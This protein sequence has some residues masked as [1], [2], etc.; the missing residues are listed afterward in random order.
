MCRTPTGQ[1]QA[2]PLSERHGRIYWTPEHRASSDGPE[3]SEQAD[4]GDHWPTAVG[5]RRLS[6]ELS[7]RRDTDPGRPYR[8]GNRRLDDAP[9]QSGLF[10]CD[11]PGLAHREGRYA[12]ADH[13]GVGGGLTGWLSR[14]CDCSS[15]VRQVQQ[16]S[17]RW[18][19]FHQ[20]DSCDGTGVIW[21]TGDG[22]CPL[23]MFRP[24]P[25]FQFCPPRHG[26]GFSAA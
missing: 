7:G 26:L 9:V 10:I 13:G 21:N 25:A 20:I 2:G 11:E 18:R 3:T 17:G 14:K 24:L 19:A 15:P 16:P 22:V 5:D 8:D 23:V 12:D 4:I 6:Q 1:E